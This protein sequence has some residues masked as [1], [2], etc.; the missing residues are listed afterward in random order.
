MTVLLPE[1]VS[2]PRLAMLVSAA[3]ADGG[4]SSSSPGGDDLKFGQRVLAEL[5]SLFLVFPAGV[6]LHALTERAE[7]AGDALISPPL[8]L[9]SAGEDRFILAGAPGRAPAALPAAGRVNGERVWVS[10]YDPV[11][12]VLR[13]APRLGERRRDVLSKAAERG[14]CWLGE[15][16]RNVL[17]EAAERLVRELEA[18]G[19]VR[20]GAE[21]VDSPWTAVW[22]DLIRLS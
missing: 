2:R 8:P 14:A 17:R 9:V 4:V 13:A 10:E 20:G 6:S 21:G 3:A 22:P 16:R 7:E 11:K 15:R 1:P 19:L 18:L 12:R 5:L